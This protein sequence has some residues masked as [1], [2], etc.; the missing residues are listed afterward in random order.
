LLVCGHP[1]VVFAGNTQGRQIRETERKDA[2]VHVEY[3]ATDEMRWTH[4]RVDASREGESIEA[5]SVTQ[6][7]FRPAALRANSRPMA[8][9]VSIEVD[10]PFAQRSKEDPTWFEPEVR[11]HAAGV[12]DAL[13]IARVKITVHRHGASD[14]T[15]VGASGAAGPGIERPQRCRAVESTVASLIVKL[16]AYIGDSDIMPLLARPRQETAGRWSEPQTP[17]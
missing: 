5:L 2:I 12:S 3:R 8:A 1:H 17:L 6:H 7:E 16:P 14:W 15:A 10:G 11:G 13:W 9:L 4:A